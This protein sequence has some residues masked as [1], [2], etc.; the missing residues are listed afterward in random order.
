MRRIQRLVGRGQTK[1]NT[2]KIDLEYIGK[3]VLVVQRCC[4]N[5]KRTTDWVRINDAVNLRDDR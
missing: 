2:F 1:H 3:K 5:R 4:Q